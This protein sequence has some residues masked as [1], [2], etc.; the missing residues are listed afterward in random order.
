MT[1]SHGVVSCLYFSKMLTTLRFSRTRKGLVLKR[2]TLH[3][4]ALVALCLPVA[5]AP[6]ET[7]FFR[8]EVP[9]GWTVSRNPSGLWQLTAPGP[10]PL[11]AVVS[12]ARLT[13]A[14]DLYLQSTAAL[15]KSLG[16]VEPLP[17]WNSDRRNQAWFLVKHTAAAGETPMATVKWVRWRG[18]LLL[19]AS[20][21]ASQDA[22]ASWEPQIR[23]LAV[24]LRVSRPQ[25]NEG[26]LRE[27]IL[28][29]LRANDMGREALGNVEQLRLAM[30]VARQDWEPF[31]GSGSDLASLEE[32]PLL[33]RAYLAYLEARYEAGFAIVHGAELGMGPDIVE[34][35]LRSVEVRRSEL[36]REAQ[37]F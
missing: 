13:A 17:P 22:L 25:F 30:N 6:L 2:L 33:Y 23:A 7:P 28:G 24:E 29:V 15:W 11:E 18:P 5:A 27:E 14:P 8:W 37:G 3:F 35:R 32:Q 31:F 26:R 20:F 9:K 21:K 36:R 34:S 1:G 12:V 16:T 4:I 10:E 19:V